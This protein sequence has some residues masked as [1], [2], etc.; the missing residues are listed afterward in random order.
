MLRKPMKLF[1][2]LTLLVA[3]LCTSIEV[4]RAQSIAITDAAIQKASLAADAR[5]AASMQ[6][7]ARY[8]APCNPM[9][10]AK[11]GAAIGFVMGM[12]LVGRAAA[13]NGG[14]VS[15]K[16]TLAV[17]GYGAAMGALI[18]LKTCR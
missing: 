10:R 8:R 1:N 14:T 2:V 15:A 11:V 7:R 13:E 3:L 6:R 12:V 16:G 9:R 18:G 5:L 4:A 17:G